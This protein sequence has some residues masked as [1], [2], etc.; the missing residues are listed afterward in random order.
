VPLARGPAG[1][2]LNLPLQGRLLPL[3]QRVSEWQT[4]SVTTVRILVML[5]RFTSRISPIIW[6]HFRGVFSV[7]GRVCGR[8]SP[9][10]DLPVRGCCHGTR[11]GPGCPRRNAGIGRS[12]AYHSVCSAGRG[13]WCHHVIAGMPGLAGVL[14]LSLGSG[15]LAGGIVGRVHR[16]DRRPEVETGAPQVAAPT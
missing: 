10:A 14:C 3:K 2:V 7:A 6:S 13:E 4:I 12:A 9:S 11:C 5:H 16:D 15:S 8:R 1:S